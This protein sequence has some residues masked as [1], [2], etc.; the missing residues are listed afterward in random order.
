MYQSA[1]HDAHKV[2][3]LPFPCTRR[4]T[5]V[6]KGGQAQKVL[7]VVR[8]VYATCSEAFGSLDVVVPNGVPNGAPLPAASSAASAAQP[9]EVRPPAGVSELTGPLFE[10]LL[11]EVLPWGTMRLTAYAENCKIKRAE[12]LA[13]S[14]FE[15]RLL[16][17]LPT[18]RDLVRVHEDGSD[19]IV[20]LGSEAQARACPVPWAVGA[21]PAAKALEVFIWSN[22]EHRFKVVSLNAWLEDGHYL[23]TSLLLLGAAAVGKS[24]VL[25]M[26]SQ[27]LVLSA[28]DS[29]E[30]TYVFGKSL[31]P[32]GVLAHSGSLRGCACISLTDFDMAAARGRVLSSETVKSLFDVPEGGVLQEC[33]WRACTLPPQMPRMF[34]LNGEPA[35]YGSYFDKYEQHGLA[36]TV[37]QLDTA[38]SPG[39]GVLE[40]ARLLAE[41][42]GKIKKL[43][44]DDQAK[45]R[46]VAV[47]ICRENLVAAEVVEAMQRDNQEKAAKGAARRAAYW[48]RHSA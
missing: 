21:S 36:M 37:G 27:E 44:A 47:A 11:A 9:E 48:A 30:G 24:R 18:I 15:S 2:K 7:D 16:V 20:R 32:L 38:T 45:L 34:A 12:K 4:C 19:M 28:D 35:S 3:E 46:R 41:L 1:A 6:K 5:F 23:E 26:L 33:R 43:C 22:T 10:D 25:H 31:D 17:C 42:Q 29:G 8:A 40:R 14:V 39:V 13:L